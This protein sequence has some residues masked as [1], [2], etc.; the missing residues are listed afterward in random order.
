[1]YTRDR[2]PFFMGIYKCELLIQPYYEAQKEVISGQFISQSRQPRTVDA[3]L[4]ARATHV[5][6]STLAYSLLEGA[7]HII[8][9]MK[10]QTSIGKKSQLRLTRVIFYAGWRS[11]ARTSFLIRWMLAQS[12]IIGPQESRLITNPFLL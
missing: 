7:R 6:I 5:P 3:A 2:Y 8:R 12:S 4:G 10:P 9:L 11:R 1:M